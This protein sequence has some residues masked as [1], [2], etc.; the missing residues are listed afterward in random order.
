MKTATVK[1]TSASPISFGRF[2]NTEKLEK[3]SADEYEKRTWKEKCYFNA[4]NEVEIKA[5][6]IKNMLSEAAK[7]LSIQIKGKGKATYTKHFE[8]GIFVM[9]N[10]PIGIKRDDVQGMWLHVPADGTRGGSKRV[11]KCFPTIQEWSGIIDINILD[12]TITQEILLLHLQEAG[13]FIGLGSL[14]PRNNGIHG[15][16]EVELISFK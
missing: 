7:F 8:A 10:M 5:F 4:N 14:R 11:M 1:L 9:N 3:E 6:A 16:F 2:H 13:K 15:R 12:E